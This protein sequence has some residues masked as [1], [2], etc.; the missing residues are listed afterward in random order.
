MALPAPGAAGWANH[1][2]F[3]SNNF[4][5]DPKVDNQWLPLVPGTQFVYDGQVVGPDGRTPHRVVFTVTD[6]TKVVNGV[7][8]MVVWDRDMSDGELAEEELAFHAQDTDGTVWLLGEYPEEHE[9]G[10]FVGAPST[11]IAGRADAQAGILMRAVPRVGTPAYFQGIAPDVEFQDKARVS[12][13]HQKTCVPA[14]CYHDVLVIDEWNP[15]EQ[16]Q[17]GHQFKYHA[18]GVGVVRIEAVGGEEQETLK[19]VKVKHLGA[20]ALARANQR[21]LKLDKRAYRVAGDVYRHTPPAE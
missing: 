19:L 14:G 8:T 11:W 15:L 20:K 16:P 6:V 3:D 1:E 7:R 10:V 5:A 18:P 17:D 9:D 12:E 13:E 21:V 4:P 2:D